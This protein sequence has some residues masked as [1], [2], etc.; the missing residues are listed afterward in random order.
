MGKLMSFLGGGCF[1]Y[2]I[3]VASTDSQMFFGILGL[4]LSLIV[5]IMEKY[6][7]SGDGGS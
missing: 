3:V 4:S 5:A 6:L 7:G 2:L 1:V